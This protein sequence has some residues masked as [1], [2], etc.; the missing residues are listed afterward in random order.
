MRFGFILVLFA[1]GLSAC[2]P[3]GRDAPDSTG[4]TARPAIARTLIMVMRVEPGSLAAKPLRSTGI[5]TANVVRIFN[6]DLA[7][8]DGQD[9]PLP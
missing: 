8:K 4:G 7:A 5:G 6:A 3:A 2:A 9:N 1:I